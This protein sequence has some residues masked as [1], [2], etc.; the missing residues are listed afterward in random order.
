MPSVFDLSNLWKYLAAWLVMLLVS[1]ANGAARDFTYSRYLG[2]LAAH[3]ISTASGIL[4]LGAVIWAFGRLVPPAS[5][6]EAVSVGLFWAA[7][8]VA[9]EF[10]F[11]HIVGGHSWAELLANYNVLEGRVWVFVVLWIAVAPCAFFRFRTA[12][13]R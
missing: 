5:A 8:T 4:L 6:R 13:T 12:I 10:L 7:L 1:V 3:Q 2:E 9:F 11:F